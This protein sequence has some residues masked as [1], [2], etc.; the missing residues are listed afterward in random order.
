MPYSAARG[1]KRA[2]DGIH[3]DLQIRVVEHHERIL[4]A[5]LELNLCQP[6]GARLRDGAAH[7]DRSVKLTPATS[8]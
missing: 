4:A 5:H 6:G 8:G 7:P 2:V 1:E 3:H